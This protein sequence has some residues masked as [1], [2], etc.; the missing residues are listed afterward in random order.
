M[1]R[2]VSV[3]SQKSLANSRDELNRDTSTPL[4]ADEALILNKPLS[5]DQ[6]TD[7]FRELLLYGCGQEAL[8]KFQSHRA[9]K[10]S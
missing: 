6:V 7:Q 8:G 3:I 1:R 10:S 5:I 2:R 4:D 9:S